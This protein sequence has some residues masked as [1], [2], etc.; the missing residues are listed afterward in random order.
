LVTPVCE[1]LR[2]HLDQLH[3]NYVHVGKHP[4]G[5]D[6]ESELLLKV[7]SVVDR[8]DDVT[9]DLPNLPVL[10]VRSERVDG[11]VQRRAQEHEGVDHHSVVDQVHGALAPQQ[12]FLAHLHP[13]RL[14]LEQVDERQEVV[15]EGATVK[16]Y[17][18]SILIRYHHEQRFEVLYV[19]DDVL[20][21]V[22]QLGVVLLVAP[23]R[24]DVFDDVG[25]DRVDLAVRKVLD[26]VEDPGL[27]ARHVLFHFF[28][29][30]YVAPRRVQDLPAVVQRRGRHAHAQAQGS[31]ERVQRD[32]LV[33]ALL[34]HLHELQRPLG[35]AA[36]LERRHH[37]V[38]NQ[39]AE[40]GR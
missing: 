32:S 28:Q 23:V 19:E 39:R 40:R 12:D 8:L 21:Y 9:Q 35:D 7:A 34:H 27:G 25:Q 36:R 3:E 13:D 30:R 18:A 17:R 24:C 5:L 15:L 6:V 26:D 11:V 31:Q 38:E 1:D 33:E 14:L 20:D 37:R 29:G 4:P 22:L 16:L 10:V 2:A